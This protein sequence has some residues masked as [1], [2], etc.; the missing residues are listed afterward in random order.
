MSKDVELAM[1][2]ASRSSSREM[3]DSKKL[4]WDV[5]D[6]LPILDGRSHLELSHAIAQSSRQSSLPIVTG[7]V[8]NI[9][10]VGGFEFGTW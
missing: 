7:G 9:V 3:W 10:R 5:L 1:L 6:D 2:N 4:T 8:E